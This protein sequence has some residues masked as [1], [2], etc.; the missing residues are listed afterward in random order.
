MSGQGRLGKNDRALEG[1]GGTREFCQASG[2]RAPTSTRAGCREEVHGRVFGLEEQSRQSPEA[3][4]SRASGETGSGPASTAEVGLED[5]EQWAPESKVR[6]ILFRT[7]D[8][9]KG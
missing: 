7:A 1:K 2:L 4:R 9:T 8:L 6:S 3:H 5:T